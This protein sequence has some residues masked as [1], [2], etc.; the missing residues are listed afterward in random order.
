MAKVGEY[1]NGFEEG[2]R[3]TAAPWADSEQV[4]DNTGKAGLLGRHVN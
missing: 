3:V 4:T 2:Q 1:V